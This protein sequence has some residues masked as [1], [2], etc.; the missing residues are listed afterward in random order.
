MTRFLSTLSVALVCAMPLASAHVKLTASVPAAGSVGLAPPQLVLV[1]NAPTRLIAVNATRNGVDA[2]KFGA[3]PDAAASRFT[4]PAGRFEPGTY[5]VDYRTM[6]ADSHAM[7]GKFAFTVVAAAATVAAAKPPV[8]ATTS[9]SSA[10]DPASAPMTDGEIRKIDTAAGTLTLK[11]GEIVNLDMPGM[12][13]V[14]IARDRAALQAL[15]V[16]DK[17][18]F[19]AVREGTKF[20]VTEIVAVK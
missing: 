3:L 10:M 8:A 12:T 16:G 5:T 6:G 1:F 15:K 18:R 9:A 17:V 14:F 13:M 20:I 4:L 19:R 7:S 11:H 2:G